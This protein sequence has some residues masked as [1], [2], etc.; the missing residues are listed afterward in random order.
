MWMR[1]WVTCDRSEEGGVEALGAEDVTAGWM[2]AA[3]PL[4]TSRIPRDDLPNGHDGL[5]RFAKADR[6][7]LS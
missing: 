2:S 6:T 3:N 5:S 1:V 7:S 4:T